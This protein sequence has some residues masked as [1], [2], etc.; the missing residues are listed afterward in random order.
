M[1]RV[2]PK[3]HEKLL[4]R[5]D[6]LIAEG[7]TIH[8]A[9]ERVPPQYTPGVVR[10]GSG[11]LTHYTRERFI[12][13]WPSFVKWRT[14][15]ATLLAQLV[16]PGHVHRQ[17]VENLSRLKN[18]KDQLEYGISLLRSLREDFCAGR[19]DDLAIAVEAELAADYMGQAERLLGGN[20]SG[21]YDHVPAAVLAGAVLEKTLRT[22]CA[23]QEPPV[24]TSKANGEPKTLNPLIDDLKK[25]GLF[26]ETKAKLLRHWADVRN[27]AAHAEFGQFTRNDVQQMIQGI[28]T[29][30]ADCLA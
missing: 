16:P 18:K 7:E 9:M 8:G 17:T 27:K 26:S 2:P 14:S 5:F 19:L 11:G 28:N 1:T 3:L 29:F 25:S 12:V 6:E 20:Q 15:I 10:T 24:S 4:S 21:E 22:L 13:D 23:M 30:L